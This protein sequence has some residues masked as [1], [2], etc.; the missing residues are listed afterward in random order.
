MSKSP[1]GSALNQLS[2]ALAP[3]PPLLLKSAPCLTIDCLVALLP[4]L[5]L[6]LDSLDEIQADRLTAPSCVPV[7]ERRREDEQRMAASRLAWDK[8]AGGEEQCS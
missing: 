3:A 1:F 4:L 8:V 5:Q 7:G 6:L 2:C